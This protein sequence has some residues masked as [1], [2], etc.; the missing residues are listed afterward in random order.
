MV[1]HSSHDS[2]SLEF[3]FS[4]GTTSTKVS[5]PRRLAERPDLQPLLKKS[6]ASQEQSPKETE[7]RDG[8]KGRNE[9]PQPTSWGSYHLNWEKLDDP[10]FNPFGSDSKYNGQKA[11]LPESPKNRLALPMAEQQ[12]AG[13]TDVETSPSQ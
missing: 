3:D 10:N 12:S 4:D 13:P 8:T 1:I 9:C 7:E 2:I 6:E 11:K 5:S